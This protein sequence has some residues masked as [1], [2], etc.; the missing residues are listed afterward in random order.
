MEI[1]ALAAAST[2]MP[3]IAHRFSAIGNSRARAMRGHRHM[4]LLVGRGR[5]AN[6]PWPDGP[7]GLFSA[8]SAAEVTC[9]DH[10]PGIQARAAG[11]ERRQAGQR[12]VDQ[13]GDAPLRDRAD[14]AQRQRD[15]VGGE[16]DRLGVEVAARHG[17]RRSQEHQRV[18]GDAVG[19]GRRA[20]R[21]RGAARRAGAHAPAAGSAG[22]KG[23]ARGR[24]RGARPG[25]RCRPCSARSAA[26]TRSGRD[27]RA[28][29]G[30][31]RRTA[32]PS[33]G[34]VGGSAPVTRAALRTPSRRET[35]RPA[36]ARWRP[37]CR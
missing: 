19:L 2:S 32:C 10:E 8:T 23:P 37:G 20:C 15:H 4:V 6:R 18:V 1:A 35:G 17:T 9:G 27:G 31:A 3:M 24:R 14:L 22:N 16:G 28:A 29:P 36:P 25:S 5:D 7:A 34:G 11:Q 21:R 30:C 26:A 33:H 13:H 12:R